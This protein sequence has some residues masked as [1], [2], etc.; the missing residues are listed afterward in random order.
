MKNFKLK[1]VRVPDFDT[2]GD[3]HYGNAP[4]GVALDIYDMEDNFIETGTDW[5][6]FAS[7]TEAD[8][9]CLKYNNNL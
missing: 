6:Y 9:Y 3:K 1:A 8:E 4:Y 2:V 7:E 5:S